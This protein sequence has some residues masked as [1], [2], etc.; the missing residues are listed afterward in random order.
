MQISK[1]VLAGVTA[2]I[3]AFAGMLQA[4]DTDAQIKAREALEKKL[5]EGQSQPAVATNVAPPP[6]PVTKPKA[7]PKP[8]T[9]PMPAPSTAGGRPIPPGTTRAP[10][11][12]PPARTETT[13]QPAQ[14]APA[15]T[16]PMPPA[17]DDAAIEKAR[18]ALHQKM[19]QTEP[20]P[21][22]A[23]APQ[24]QAPK[25][26]K[27]AVVGQ[28][29]PKPTPIPKV[30]AQPAPAVPAPA[31]VV[32]KAPELQSEPVIAPAEDSPEII[33]AREALHQKMNQTAGQTTSSASPQPVTSEPKPV[34]HSAAGT[35]QK[36]MATA[37]TQPPSAPKAN[38]PQRTK[39]EDAAKNVADKKPKTTPPPPS[40]PPQM[41][42]N[43]GKGAATFT[44]L[45]A[46]PL[47]ISADKQRRLADL[48]TKYQADQLTPQQYHQQRA[49]ILAEP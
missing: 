46:P 33:K 26:T 31:P 49:K 34:F 23:P 39:A 27:P 38:N 36:N 16:L 13:A 24:V 30:L 29:Q 4:R 18:E 19:N 14:T 41:N 21:T 32:A 17:A 3:C 45:Q 10:V 37:Q 2:S 7:A 5:S 44:P 8:S 1:I 22:P 20:A 42:A 35:D 28:P 40:K 9:A 47:P 25:K 12:P 6:A 15:P 48:L 11:M 43:A